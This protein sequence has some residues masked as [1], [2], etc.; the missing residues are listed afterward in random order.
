MEK[1]GKALI[2]APDDCSGLKTLTKDTEKIE[3]LYK[4]GYSK[5]EAI[6]DFMG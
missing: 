6:I 2:I 1:E 4:N 5:A 3:D